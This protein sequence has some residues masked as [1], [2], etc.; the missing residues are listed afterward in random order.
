MHSEGPGMITEDADFESVDFE[1]YIAQVRRGIHADPAPHNEALLANILTSENEAALMRAIDELNTFF[2]RPIPELLDAI[3]HLFMQ[4]SAFECQ[5]LRIAYTL[6]L[7]EDMRDAY[8]ER[9]AGF[10]SEIQRLATFLL[11]GLDP[12]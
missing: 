6:Y 1:T 5:R 11:S 3:L 12:F 9:T 10:E 2:W 7:A 8:A 4:G